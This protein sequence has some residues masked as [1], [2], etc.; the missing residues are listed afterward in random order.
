[1]PLPKNRSNSVRKIHKR[2][3]KGRHAIHY[4]RVVKGRSHSCALCGCRLQAVASVQ[5]LHRGAKSPNRKFGGNL[6]T[7]CASRIIVEAS[8][9]AEGTLSLAEVSVSRLP[10]VKRL[11]SSKS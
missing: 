9:V 3:P 7:A 6:C 8:R 1:M 5:G 11:N 2:T 4:V 10:Y